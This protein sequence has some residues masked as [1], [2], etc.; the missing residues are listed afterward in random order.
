MQRYQ[1]P[2]RRLKNTVANG[3]IGAALLGPRGA[4]AG[5][6]LGG[7]GNVGFFG[8]NRRRMG[9]VR[10]SPRRVMGG[11]LDSRVVGEAIGRLSG[12]RAHRDGDLPML[13]PL[14]GGK[15]K[16]RFYSP[17]SVM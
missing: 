3:L 16:G 11:D 7:I 10:R 2:N 14:M 1:D 9:R 17:R 8:G 4:V 12:G 5:A 13:G 15:R 6:A